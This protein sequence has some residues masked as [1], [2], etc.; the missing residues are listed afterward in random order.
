MNIVSFYL[1]QHRFE[2]IEANGLAGEPC[3]PQLIEIRFEVGFHDHTKPDDH[4]DVTLTLQ[5]A[6]RLDE[7][8]TEELLTMSA[9]GTFLFHEGQEPQPIK[10]PL[11]RLYAGTLLYGA[12]RPTLDSI[13]ANLG[14]RGLSMPLNLPMDEDGRLPE[15][16]LD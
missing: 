6:A 15:R 14:L 2:H 8:R 5:L 3:K 12:V 1:D 16:K 10:E 11:E 7:E 9:R 4:F 13:V